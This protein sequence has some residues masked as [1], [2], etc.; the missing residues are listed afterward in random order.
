MR[1]LF[2]CVLSLAL[3]TALSGQ[4]QASTW[5]HN[6]ST[7]YLIARGPSREFY[8]KQPRQGMIE[9]GARPGSLLFSGE[10]ANGKYVGTAYIFDRHCGQ[11]P[12]NVSGPILDNYTRV[13]LTGLA[14]R[15]GPIVRSK[16]IGRIRLS[17]PTW[18]RGRLHRPP[19]R[20]PVD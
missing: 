5:E 16:A 18:N 10:T 2:L 1:P 9:A 20:P 19:N 15:V 17:L 12:C 13:V 7:L 8:Y 4:S 6:G 3:T 14:P 11:F